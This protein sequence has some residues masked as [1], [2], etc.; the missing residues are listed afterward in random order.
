[1]ALA[2]ITG[3]MIHRFSNLR[4]EL[5]WQLAGRFRPSVYFFTL[6]KCASTLFTDYVL[7]AVSGLRHVDYARQLWTGAKIDE[8][9]FRARGYLYGP[10][11]VI[12][13]DMTIDVN[14]TFRL[15]RE[16]YRPDRDHAVFM[17]RDPRDILV[18]HYYSTA[19]SHTFSA[20]KEHAERARKRRE[21]ALGQTLDEYAIGWM[22]NLLVRYRLLRELE[23]STRHKV[24]IRY[25]DMIDDWDTFRQGLTRALDISK[26]TLGML[27]ERSRPNECEDIHAH[28]RSGLVGQYRTRFS[29]D[30]IRILDREFADV[31]HR[32]GYAVR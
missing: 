30:T 5:Y 18:S 4:K 24:I 11:R 12:V 7:P 25:E 9:T 27:Y 1:M 20:N 14:R 3:H 17:V 2:T 22:E 19:Y 6:H 10:I 29:A 26:A 23:Q 16:Q 31:L 21:Q 15:A 8:M 32:Y 28:K 13:D